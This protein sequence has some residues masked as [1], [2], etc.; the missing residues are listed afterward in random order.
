MTL[1]KSTLPCWTWNNKFLA[2]CVHFRA[3]SSCQSDTSTTLRH[4][5][6]FGSNSMPSLNCGLALDACSEEHD[7]WRP[8]LELRLLL[9]RQV[10]T[11]EVRILGPGGTKLFSKELL[12]LKLRA[13]WKRPQDPDGI[14]LQA[15]WVCPLQRGHVLAKL[16]AV[17]GRLNRP[18]SETQALG[19]PVGKIS[20]GVGTHF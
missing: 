4:T 5:T 11:C 2:A 17:W 13:L 6:A 15:V 16:R 3:L 9:A 10:R 1:T 20:D 8:R 18:P 19:A 14:K 7:D 12:V